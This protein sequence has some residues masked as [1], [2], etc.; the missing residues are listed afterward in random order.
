[1]DYK[2]YEKWWINKF[3]T[4]LLTLF[5]FI[6]VVVVASSSSLYRKTFLRF[7]DVNETEFCRWTRLEPQ[8]TSTKFYNGWSQTFLHE[9][10][11]K[12]RKMTLFG[13]LFPTLTCILKMQTRIEVR[14]WLVAAGFPPRTKE[15]LKKKWEDLSSATKAKYA[16]ERRLGVVQ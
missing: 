10:K 8:K 2:D 11:K 9:V 15:Q 13:T 5:S 16:H 7:W 14:N 12:K 4:L 1:M 6:D 3:L